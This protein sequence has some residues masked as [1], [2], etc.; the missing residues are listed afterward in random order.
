M[1]TLRASR[2]VLDAAARRFQA[3]RLYLRAAAA[4]RWAIQRT[5]IL[6]GQRPSPA[7]IPSLKAAHDTLRQVRHYPPV[8]LE[9]ADSLLIQELEQVTDDYV[10]SDLRAADLRAGHWL[11][12]DPTLETIRCWIQQ[13]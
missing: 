13:S 10:L 12:D 5:N 7:H 3:H 2:V 1:L 8:P 9:H 6:R 4:K 11:D